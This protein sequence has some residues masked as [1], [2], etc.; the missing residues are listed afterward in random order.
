MPNRTAL[1][2]S[3]LLLATIV[4]PLALA[5]SRRAVD[6]ER[7]LT[8]RPDPRT[9]ALPDGDEAFTFAVFGDRT[10]GP[11]EGVRVLAQAVDDV[12]LV[13]PDLVMTVGDLIQGYN[14]T[15]PWLAEMREFRG[16]MD[17]LRAP[18]F[19]VAGNHDIYWRGETPAPPGEHEGHYEQHF[20]PL[21]YAFRHKGAWFV[22]LYSDEGDPETGEKSISKPSCQ[23]MSPE[24]VAWLERT[25]ERTRDARHVFV[26][27]HHPRWLTER[28]GDD[29]GKVHDVL[30]RAGNVRAVFAGHI[31]HMRYDPRDG[32]EYFTLATVGGHQN[33]SVPAAGYLHHYELVTVRDDGIDVV[34]Y[35]VGEATDPRAITGAVSTESRA[36]FDALGPVFRERVALAA[37]GSASGTWRFGLSNPTER[38][39]EL[40]IA[41]RS[42]DPRW[43]F[44][45]GRRELRLAPGA[46]VDV[47]LAAERAAAP[48]TGTFRLPEL[49]VRAD[50]LAETAAADWRVDLPE[51]AFELELDLR[52]LPAPRRPAEERALALDGRDDWLAVP[53]RAVPLPD[54][55]FTLEG[56]FEA[57]ELR[58][59]QSLVAK[60]ES[61]E[62][63]LSV[64]SGRPVFVVHLDGG[65]VVAAADRAI[66]P[67]RWHH[68]AGVFDGSE[69]R[70][71]VDGALT[72]RTAG[73][74]E[75]TTNDLPL[76]VGG[77]VDGRG[78]GTSLFAGRI[79]EV[80]LSTGA[81]YDGAFEP[82]R[83]VAADE[84]TRLL[85][86]MDDTVGPWT[87]DVSG[88]GA[89]GRL[90]GARIAP[91][92]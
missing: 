19:P 11:P 57:R 75:R 16:V 32:I 1:L 58:P 60:T 9:L 82:A 18:W 86:Q 73:A 71:Y 22:V 29:W 35:P 53:S 88:R 40:S 26:F 20:G 46:S 90:H 4:A 23:V 39:L 14:E 42:A 3:L 55:P 78:A 6:V 2:R 45:P 49:A 91:V 37:D 65:Y 54:G 44:E 5:P 62:Y 59:R 52:A 10:G 64:A 61:S 24:Q 12:N 43:R 30:V 70:L 63:G 67:G 8:D 79:D 85:L 68:V 76:I 87:H 17:R 31:H 51:R 13:G 48:W 84:A 25:M 33:G 38:P 34:S 81:R 15:E 36:A 80:R 27:L 66:E 28:Y 41:A 92:R 69:L 74:G 72:A 50:Y 21:W 7:F 47:D 77:D 89:H 83:R 56:W